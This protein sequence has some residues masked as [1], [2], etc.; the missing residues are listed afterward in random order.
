MY[1][2]W[3]MTFINN[4]TILATYLSQVM[5]KNT[6]QKAKS[7]DE[8]LAYDTHKILDSGCIEVRALLDLQSLLTES[9]T[10]TWHGLSAW[11]AGNLLFRWMCL[12]ICKS[13]RFK[14]KK[15]D[16]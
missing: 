1:L 9:N 7:R 10:F 6:S 15:G 2:T 14:K 13:Y 11:E 5:F 8:I 4:L 16:T 12:R 3:G